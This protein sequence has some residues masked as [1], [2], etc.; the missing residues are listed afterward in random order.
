MERPVTGNPLR[1]KLKLSTVIGSS[2]STADC[3]LN[4]CVMVP[5]LIWALRSGRKRK[6]EVDVPQYP[7]AVQVSGFRSSRVLDPWILPFAS[8]YPSVLVSALDSL[9]LTVSIWVVLLQ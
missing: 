2:A 6:L 9:R 5:M 4:I 8:G 7:K 1:A 3:V